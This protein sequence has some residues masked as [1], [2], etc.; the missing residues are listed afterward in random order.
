MNERCRAFVRSLKRVE[1]E[2]LLPETD[3]AAEEEDEAEGGGA[4][5]A[6]FVGRLNAAVDDEADVVIVGPVCVAA[7]ELAVLALALAPAPAPVY[8]DGLELLADAENVPLWRF[9]GTSGMA[10]E[11]EVEPLTAVRRSSATFLSATAASGREVLVESEMLV[12]SVA[13]GVGAQLVA[14]RD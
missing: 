5:A 12:V 6:T 9:D 3:G 2:A 1:F 13:A 11:A 7:F 10:A 14:I 8:C 4:S